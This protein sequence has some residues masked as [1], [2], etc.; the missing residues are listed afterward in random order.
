[1]RPEI[2]SIVGKKVSKKE[3]AARSIATLVI[4]GSAIIG[5]S[6]KKAEASQYL[7]SYDAS[8]IANPADIFLR[9]VYGPQAPTVEQLTMQAGQEFR[10]GIENAQKQLEQDALIAGKKQD[11]Q[12][13]SAEE[14]SSVIAQS[15]SV[16]SQTEG[17]LSLQPCGGEYPP[18]WVAE[19]ESHGNYAAVNSTGCGGRTCG[20][21][22]QFDPLTWDGYGG[23][24]FAQ[25]AP[26]A[27]QDSKAKELW[28]GGQGCGHWAA[29]E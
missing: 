3:F 6:A 23:Y 22:W 19:R 18:C 8:D 7:T 5:G 17:N 28:N 24:E 29:C 1:M 26:P 15:I 21:K 14:P 20:G 4:A 27:L 25:D 2:S 13:K 10:I 11:V 12:D 9:P 16:T